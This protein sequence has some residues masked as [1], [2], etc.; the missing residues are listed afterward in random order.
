MDS[1]KISVLIPLY[2]RKHYIEQCINSVLMQTFQDFEIIVR[3]DGSTDGSANFIEEKYSAEISSNKLKLRRNEKNI[4]EFLTDNKLLR[5]ATGKYIMILHSDDLYLSN[6]L[7]QMYSVAEKFQA[8]VVHS[9]NHLTT[10]PDGIIKEGTTLRLV[11]HDAQ[12]S[13]ETEIISDAPLARVDEWNFGGTFIDAQYNIF[14]RKFLMNNNLRFETF[15][16][17]R[18]FALGWIMRAKILVKTP[19]LFYV[20]RNSPDS[21]TNAKCPPE[22]VVKFISNQIELSRYL[23]KFF[24]ADDFFKDNLEMQYRTRSHLFLAY[25]NYDISSRGVY[26]DGITP[27]LN[28]AV[29]GAFKKYFDEDYAFPTFLFHW[30]HA[31]IFNQR[32]DRLT[33]S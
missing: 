30:I 18:L 22:R 17:N 28:Q 7:E 31:A 20:Y 27:E 2:N 25:D 13:N 12:G 14:N 5:E 29:E 23:D 6:A 4:G 10:A 19:V 8:D 9:S 26:K 3:D 15:G 21:V 16:G 11:C 1:P 24:V 32:V 33:D